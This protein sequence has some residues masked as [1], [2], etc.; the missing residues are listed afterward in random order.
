MNPP[1]IGLLL[2]TLQ[3]SQEPNR[4]VRQPA[5]MT[6]QPTAMLLTADFVALINGSVALGF[7]FIWAE[8]Y[9]YHSENTA[10][11]S[12]G[13]C[14]RTKHCSRGSQQTG[15]AGDGAASQRSL[16]VL[17]PEHWGPGKFSCLTQAAQRGVTRT[18]VRT[19]FCS[20]LPSLLAFLVFRPVHPSVE[21]S[22]KA[23]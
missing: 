19:T 12:M 4:Q 8:V 14:P 16:S 22:R 21:L 10:D 18:G 9:G 3:I 2:R 23:K 1:P 7:L 5:E 17:W 13:Y 15:K 20:L 6:L 11:V